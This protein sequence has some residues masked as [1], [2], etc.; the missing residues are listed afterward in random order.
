MCGGQTSE[1]RQQNEV[2]VCGVRYGLAVERDNKICR[3]GL[4]GECGGQTQE[5]NNQ[6]DWVDW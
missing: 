3:S 5:R 1:I 4:T 2:N 6:I